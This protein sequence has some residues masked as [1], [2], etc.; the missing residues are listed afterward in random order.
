MRAVVTDNRQRSRFEL[1]EGGLT[2]FANYHRSGQNLVISH[3]E[4]PPALRGKGTAARLMEGVTA[5][6]E[7]EG[8]KVTPLCSYAALWFRRHPDRAGV[9]A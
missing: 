7:A 2:A 9:L 3:V 8:L 5:I 1:V 6:A 4:S